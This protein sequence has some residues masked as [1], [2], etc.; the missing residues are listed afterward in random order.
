[1]WFG[2]GG[3]GPE[4]WGPVEGPKFR[5]FFPPPAT[6][7]ILSS[8]LWGSSRGIL[9]VFEGARD[10]KCARLEFSGCSV[11]SRRPQ[12]LMTIGLSSIWPK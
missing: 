12:N 1:M 11:K 3:W 8:L 7:F 2:P 4:E 5:A 10:L 9:V 6:I